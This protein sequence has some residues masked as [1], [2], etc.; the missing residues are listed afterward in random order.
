MRKVHT[1]TVVGKLWRYPGAAG[2]HFVYVSK[3]DAAHIRARQVQTTGFG[4]VPVTAC[5]GETSWKTTLFPSKKEATYLLAIKAQ[6]R[7]KESLL[8][9]DTVTARVSL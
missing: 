2:W 7:K 1:Y 5:I 3:E 8:E 6:V 4:F 9:G